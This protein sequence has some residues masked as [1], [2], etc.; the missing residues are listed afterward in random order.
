[1]S[2]DK[3]W[4]SEKSFIIN[5]TFQFALFPENPASTLYVSFSGYAD[6]ETATTSYLETI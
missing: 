2:K 5:H 6:N 3:E 4:S 1:L